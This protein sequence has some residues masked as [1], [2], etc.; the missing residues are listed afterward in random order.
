MST[1]LPAARPARMLRSL[2][3][4][5]AATSAALVLPAAA[6]AGAADLRVVVEK[7]ATSHPDTPAVLNL[8]IE[9][10]GET[11]YDPDGPTA[12]SAT[13]IRWRTPGEWPRFGA[14]VRSAHGW[15]CL[16]SSAREGACVLD[17]VIPAGGSSLPVEVEV[18]PEEGESSERRYEG[19]VDIEGDTF[20]IP[21]G[22]GKPSLVAFPI[23]GGAVDPQDDGSVPLV[24]DESGLADHPRAPKV[25][26]SVD[27]P[28]LSGTESAVVTFAFAS[29]GTISTGPFNWQVFDWWGGPGPAAVGV[30]RSY[31]GDADEFPNVR[32]GV[33]L[34]AS[35]V[36]LDDLKVYGLLPEHVESGG[37]VGGSV[38]R[39]GASTAPQFGEAPISPEHIESGAATGEHLITLPA[40]GRLLTDHPLRV[41]ATVHFQ[42]G[43]DA[44]ELLAEVSAPAD[45]LPSRGSG[46]SAK[47]LLGGLTPPAATTT[48]S[49]TRAP[50]PVVEQP[51]TPVTPATPQQPAPQQQSAPDQGAVLA[52]RVAPKLTGRARFAKQRIFVG[53]Q[54]NLTLTVDNVGNGGSDAGQVCTKL[55]RHIVVVKLPKGVSVQ[56]SKLCAKRSALAPNGTLR[57]AS[58]IVVRGVLPTSRATAIDGVNDGVA[59]VGD[60]LQVV[61]VPARPGGV[62]G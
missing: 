54:T 30:G 6:H 13:E 38:G 37:V 43:V 45:P 18:L 2:T 22:G 59:L 56:G 5:V 20:V 47:A 25:S 49:I 16:T 33:T 46:V 3:A 26:G 55:S 12:E 34:P 57:A 10:R 48:V 27:K 51:V 40:G 44:A 28:Q 9:N 23:V 1:E 29:A 17:H 60:R 53:R 61:P 4:L 52:A 24:F 31:N 15:D 41:V 11:A 62:T 19:D 32:I 7:T 42:P 58:G 50:A 8:R 14:S 21:D 39:A 36:V 35:Q